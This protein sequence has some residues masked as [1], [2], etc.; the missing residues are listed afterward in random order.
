[1]HTGGDCLGLMGRALDHDFVVNVQH[2]VI[3]LAQ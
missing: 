2:D 1:V 3:E